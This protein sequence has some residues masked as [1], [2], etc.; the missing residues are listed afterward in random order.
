MPSFS[1]TSKDNLATAEEP[2]QRLFNRVI[3]K[4]DCSVICGHRGREE[5]E[6]AF[7]EGKSQARFGQSKHNHYPSRAVDVVPYPIDWEDREYFAR[8]AGY[9][10]AVADD[11]GINIRWGGDWDMDNRSNDETFSDLPHFELMD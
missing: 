9:V 10:Q 3:K 7:R 8:F 5:Q 11:E 4:F 6:K 1:Q 2:L